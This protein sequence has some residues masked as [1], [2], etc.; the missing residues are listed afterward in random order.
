MRRAAVNPALAGVALAVVVGAIVAT[1]ARNA[2]T[3]VLGLFLTL[4]GA[5]F[6]A[7]PLPDS[8]GLLARLIG[9]VICRLFPVGRH[10]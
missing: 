2:R 8:L 1:S 9:S 10:P 4:V 5:P 3:A 7:D 6:V